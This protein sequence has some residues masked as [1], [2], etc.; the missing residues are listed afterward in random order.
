MFRT[1]KLSWLG[2]RGLWVG[3]IYERK[4]T[5]LPA[6]TPLIHGFL[7]GGVAHVEIE[8]GAEELSYKTDKWGPALCDVVGRVMELT[9]SI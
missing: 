4:L 7:R 1:L 5:W 9:R 6:G 8:I 3:Y 2:E